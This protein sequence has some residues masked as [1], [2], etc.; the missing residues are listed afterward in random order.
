MEKQL[1]LRKCA[2]LDAI[3]I[4]KHEEWKKLN[5][6]RKANRPFR[7]R[8]PTNVGDPNYHKR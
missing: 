6:K 7:N 2:E 5:A 4:G 1:S 3:A 8:K